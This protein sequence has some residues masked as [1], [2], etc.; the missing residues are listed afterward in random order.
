M[1]SPL[2][3]H[4]VELT[5]LG[6]QIVT[7]IPRQWSEFIAPATTHK[8]ADSQR[9]SDSRF[10]LSLPALQGYDPT[11]K[12]LLRFL[13]VTLLAPC[14]IQSASAQATAPAIPAQSPDIKLGVDILSDA[15]GVNLAPYVR[16]LV[17]DLRKHWSSQAAQS[18]QPSPKQQETVLTLTI[19]PDGQLSAMK[20][21]TPGHDS[22]LNQAAWNATKTTSFSPPPVGMTDP[23]LKLRVHFVIN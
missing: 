7:P 19:A 18:N 5:S 14:L 16:N 13:A 6:W 22:A 8:F 21:E 20:L 9:L 17:S 1:T 10:A 3:S 12:S 2:L 11:M 4:C 15:G 23:N